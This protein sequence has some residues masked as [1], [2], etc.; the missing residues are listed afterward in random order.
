MVP[1]VSDRIPR[2]PPYSGYCYEYTMHTCT[3]LSPSSIIFSKIFHFA[4]SFN[5]AVLQPHHCR[6]NSGLGYSPFARHYSENR[7]FFLFLQVL[8]CF[9]SLRWLS[10]LSDR[11]SIC[12]VSPFGYTRIT[13]CL[14][15]PAS[16]RSLPR[17]SS[18][19]EA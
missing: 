9:S 13:S 8:R 18:P 3:G 7:F 4:L 11:S 10:L 15:I 1:A 17:P 16:F 2:V 19:I 6:N 5:L 14:Q 12:R